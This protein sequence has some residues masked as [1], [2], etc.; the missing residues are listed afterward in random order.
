MEQACPHAIG[1][2]NSFRKLCPLEGPERAGKYWETSKKVV[3]TLYLKETCRIFYWEVVRRDFLKVLW[4]W[5]GNI[6]SCISPRLVLW[7]VIL[8]RSFSGVYFDAGLRTAPLDEYILSFRELGMSGSVTETC[9][10]CPRGFYPLY[11]GFLV[12][13][14][15]SFIFY[16]F[17]YLGLPC[18]WSGSLPYTS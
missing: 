18:F 15:L 1:G 3:S 4:S 13:S 7:G 2:L 16:Y 14:F 12:L 8:K 6:L 5:G 10:R 9:L 11:P 17:F